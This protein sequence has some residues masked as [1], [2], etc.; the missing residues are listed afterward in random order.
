MGKFTRA[1][2]AR[3]L[4]NTHLL[5]KEGFTFLSDRHNELK[6]DIFETRLVGKKALCI[7]G[8]EAAEKFYD[9]SL[10][11]RKNA[12][13][14]VISQS[15]LGKGI[16]G[17]DGEDH[18]HRKRM[19]L[20][21]MTPERVED[22]KDI[23]LE[24]L[25]RRAGEWEKMPSI[26]MYD[27]LREILVRT[28]CR[29]GGVPLSDAE[30]PQRTEE[31]SLMVDSFGS[32][33]RMKEGKKA[34]ESQ[35]KWLEGIIRDVRSGKLTPHPQ[36]AAYITAHYRTPSGKK[37]SARDAGIELNNAIR[38]LLA[39]AYFLVFGLLAMHQFPGEKEKIAQDQNNYSHKFSQEVRRYYP[40]APAMAAKVR[41]S[42][43]WRNVEFK[44]GTLVV[45]DFYGTNHHRDSWNSPETFQ[46]E[47]F[48]NWQ[49]SPFSFVPQGGGDH[50]SGHRCAGE[51]LTV[52]VM[53]AFFR[54]MSTGLDYHVPE[55]N[56]SWS[57]HR[58][59]TIPED[60]FRITNVQRTPGTAAL[61][62]KEEA[63]QTVIKS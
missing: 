39:T 2:R 59:P 18:L 61:L 34:R 19:F 20:S 53:K 57:L 3:G 16:H 24:E 45:L 6:S 1:P 15:L 25:D 13:P 60:G 62:Q 12:V 27:E 58:V 47:R 55:Q 44:K 30:A 40:F 51:W 48:N 46:P 17:M 21:M 43:S 28:G 11:I 31:M 8:A 36:T 22:I 23:F 54:Y 35:E 49:G 7:T 41:K 10:F 33:G 14:S 38:P 5:L 32:L 63:S 29:W 37:L 50:H 9:S 42:F 52:I 4:D 26:H 56:L